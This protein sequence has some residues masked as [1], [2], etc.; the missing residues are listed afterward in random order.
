MFG[1]LFGTALCV[2]QL[3]LPVSG[4]VV[5]T[6]SCSVNAA[7]FPTLPCVFG[8][9]FKSPSVATR[10]T[11]RSSA[12]EVGIFGWK[13]LPPKTSYGFCDQQPGLFNASKQ[14]A[15]SGGSLRRTF[16][17]ALAEA[18]AHTADSASVCTY[19]TKEPSFSIQATAA[20]L[21]FIVSAS[22]LGLR[23]AWT[24]MLVCG[25]RSS[26]RP[27][28]D[29]DGG[30]SVA[31]IFAAAATAAATAATKT[32]DHRRCGAQKGIRSALV[33]MSISTMLVLAI[34]LDLIQLTAAPCLAGPSTARVHCLARHYFPSQEQQLTGWTDNCNIG[35]SCLGFGTSAWGDFGLTVGRRLGLAHPRA[36]KPTF[37]TPASTSQ[38]RMSLSLLNSNSAAL[39]TNSR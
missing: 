1:A 27:A 3:M 39:T 34:G 21:F 19:R 37:G 12:N 22:L 38:V 13:T 32:I 29:T 23:L 20:A 4:N 5:C 6:A 31:G 30:S 16:A 9:G 36:A 15:T 35:G 28:S 14:A 24:V 7:T 26:S 33:C 25:T 17:A 10:A 2:V 8:A 11:A 18:G